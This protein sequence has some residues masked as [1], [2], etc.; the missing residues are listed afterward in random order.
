MVGLTRRDRD[1]DGGGLSDFR[2]VHFS[3]GWAL[4]LDDLSLPSQEFLEL[5]SPPLKGD[6]HSKALSKGLP[7]FRRTL[8]ISDTTKVLKSGPQKL[9]ADP[10]EWWSTPIHPPAIPLSVRFDRGC[11]ASRAKSRLAHAGMQRPTDATPR[12]NSNHS[13]APEDTDCIP[14]QPGGMDAAAATRFGE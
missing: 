9:A 10:K 12:S 3:G 5:G 11:R 6:S 7:E 13:K 14:L 2:F 1:G 8:G 4:V